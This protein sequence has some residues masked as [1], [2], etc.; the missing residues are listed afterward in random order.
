MI[1]RLMSLHKKKNH[2]TPSKRK[3]EKAK[4]KKPKEYS[5]KSY[6]FEED[7]IYKPWEAI[8]DIKRMLNSTTS[9]GKADSPQVSLEFWFPID[10]TF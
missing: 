10:T 4:K 3:D 1:L 6:C 8:D 9:L 7:E 2:Q 5:E